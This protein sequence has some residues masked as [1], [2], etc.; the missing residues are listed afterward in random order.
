MRYFMKKSAIIFSLIFITCSCDD[1]QKNSD[2]KLLDQYTR[3]LIDCSETFNKQTQNTD[4]SGFMQRHYTD[5][6]AIKSAQECY[7]KTAVKVLTHFYNLTPNQAMQRFDNYRDFIYN[8][9]LFLYGNTTRCQKENC[10]FSIYAF[11]EF[12]TTYQIDSYTYHLITS[13]EKHYN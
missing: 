12:A 3:E 1:I 11:S 13:L 8:Q 2:K 7:R 5:M 9:Y 6:D 4:N 10:G